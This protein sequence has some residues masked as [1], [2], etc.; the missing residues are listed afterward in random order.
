M[1]RTDLRRS[2]LLR[3]RKYW[4]LPHPIHHF[5]SHLIK[6]L[7]FNSGGRGL[8][9]QRQARPPTLSS[10]PETGH[11]EIFAFRVELKKKLTSSSVWS[12][13]PPHM[14]LHP[15]PLLLLLVVLLHVDHLLRVVFHHQQ[16]VHGLLLLPLTLVVVVFQAISTT[17]VLSTMTTHLVVVAFEIIL[18]AENWSWKLFARARATFDTIWRRFLS[19]I[20]SRCLFGNPLYMF[21]TFVFLRAFGYNLGEPL[22]TFWT[23]FGFPLD[24]F[25][26]IFWCTFRYPF[27]IW[28]LFGAHLNIF[29]AFFVAPLDILVHFWMF[30]T[31][32]CTFIYLLDFVGAFYYVPL[33][34]FQPR[35]VGALRYQDHLGLHCQ[36]EYGLCKSKLASQEFSEPI[37]ECFFQT[38]IKFVA[39]DTT[40]GRGFFFVLTYFF[41]EN[42]AKIFVLPE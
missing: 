19:L 42:N 33:D 22:D 1:C 36:Q 21:W 29:S 38:D 13:T 24:T 31:F 34:I 2:P 26:D 12:N 10:D 8:G 23:S 15:L 27:D 28:Y 11:Q 20:I 4:Q 9:V 3:F 17:K 25:L 37:I 16:V 14:P 18:I 30:F 39:T 6:T 32:L 40:G 35:C 41:S 7:D 5:Q